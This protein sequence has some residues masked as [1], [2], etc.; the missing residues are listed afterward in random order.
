MTDV[1]VTE[2]QPPTKRGKPGCCVRTGNWARRR[3]TVWFLSPL[4]SFVPTWS[5]GKLLCF[6]ECVDFICTM[7]ASAPNLPVHTAAGKDPARKGRSPANHSQSPLPISTVTLSKSLL[8][9]PSAISTSCL[10]HDTVGFMTVKRTSVLLTAS[11]SSTTPDTA[12][13]P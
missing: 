2:T 11:A 1:Q 5:P 13:D 4:C 12:G 7:R 10:S 9:C 8:L 6:T 3:N